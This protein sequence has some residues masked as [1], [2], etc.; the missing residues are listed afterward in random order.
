MK[1]RVVI[2]QENQ[3]EMKVESIV[4]WSMRGADFEIK[5]ED[6]LYNWY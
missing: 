4:S 5:A 3:T 2:T 1:R 6:H